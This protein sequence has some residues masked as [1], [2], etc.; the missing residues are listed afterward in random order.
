MGMSSFWAVGAL[1][2]EDVAELAPRAVPAIEA[3]AARALAVGAWKRWERDVARGGGAVPVWR[4]DGYN[5]EEALHLNGLVDGSAFD[6]MDS[7]CELHVMEWWDRFEDSVDPY[8]TSVRK[9]NPVA[10]LFHGLGPVRAAALPGWAGDAVFT[11]A[12]V[13]RSLPAVEGV[14]ALAGPER[15]RVVA[16]IDDWLCD[17]G[18]EELLDGPLRVWRDAAGAGLGL[19]ASRIW[20]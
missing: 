18:P 12:E 9:G 15:D 16:R 14:L 13:R 20:F 7:A 4:P 2:D 11:S 17:E 19:L 8:I 1:G 6:A 5:T 10:A 3:T